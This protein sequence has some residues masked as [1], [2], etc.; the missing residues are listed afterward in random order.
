[1]GWDVGWDENLKRDI[2]Y[3]IPA[4]CDHP[5]CGRPIDRGM[6][7][8]CGSDIYGG[9]W[10]CG[11]H[12]CD[13]HRQ[14]ASDRRPVMLCARCLTFKKPFTPTPDVLKWIHHKMTHPSWAEWRKENGLIKKER[15]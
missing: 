14:Y 10:G 13:A 3:G 7:Y 8:V 2:G 9:T 6:A 15:L 4:T 1:M 5:G 11:L 12:F